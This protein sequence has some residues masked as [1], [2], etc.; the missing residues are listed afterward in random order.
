[1]YIPDEMKK[2]NQF[3]DV[4]IPS[5]K[6]FFARLG[7]V[8]LPEKSFTGDEVVPENLRKV[9]ELAMYEKYAEEMASQ[10]ADKSE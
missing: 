6:S 9:D 2:V 3:E 8:T 5:N 7:S 1:M 4:A 10:E